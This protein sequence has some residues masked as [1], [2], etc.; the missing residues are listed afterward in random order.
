MGA[1]IG[2]QQKAPVEGGDLAVH[3]LVGEL[4]LLIHRRRAGEVDGQR[5]GH[6][7]GGVDEP[8]VRRVDLN[9]GVQPFFR[10]P[11]G[12][13]E[14]LGTIGAVDI[15]DGQPQPCA[16]RKVIDPLRQV[17]IGEKRDK[18]GQKKDHY[19]P[20]HELRSDAA[21]L[22]HA[23]ARFSFCHLCSPRACT[24]CRRSF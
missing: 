5:I 14:F 17:V 12:L 8:A 1:G 3:R 4:V 15:V 23:R 20:S 21:L 6:G 7:G 10:Q 22:F 2:P 13:V 11:Y 18:N 24:R 16:G 19:D 9:V